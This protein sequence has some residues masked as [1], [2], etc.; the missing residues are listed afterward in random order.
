MVQ[1]Y[2]MNEHFTKKINISNFQDCTDEIMMD[3]DEEEDVLIFNEDNK[4]SEFFS[5]IK[6]VITE[7]VTREL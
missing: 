1:K 7:D 5:F 2:K 6:Q 3:E 4:E